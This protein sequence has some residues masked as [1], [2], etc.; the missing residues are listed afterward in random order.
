MK[1]WK[2]NIGLVELNT[3]NKNTI[4]S[5]LGIENTEIGDDYLVATM[6]VD[7]RTHQPQGLLHGGASVVLA[8]TLG[9]AAANLAVLEDFECYGIEVNANHVRSERS[10]IVT[11]VTTAIHIGKSTQIWRIEIKNNRSKLVCISRL[12]LA[13]IKKPAVT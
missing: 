5:L 2:K 11:G 8:E 7:S 3:L 6:P 10:G 12:T 13:V 9:S 4:I 1:I